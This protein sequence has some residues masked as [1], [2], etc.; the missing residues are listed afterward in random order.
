MECLLWYQWIKNSIKLIF[1]SN[2]TVAVMGLSVIF[3]YF[4]QRKNTRKDAAKIIVQEIRRAED[5]IMRYKEQGNFQFTKKII[6][7]NSWGDNIHFFVNDL[8]QDEL[9]K[10]SNLYSTG[11]FFDY[12]IQRIFNYQF[13]ENAN[14]S[15]EATLTSPIKDFWTVLLTSLVINYDFVYHTEIV[16]KLKRIA[17]IK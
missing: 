11:E 4:W 9:D 15:K 2:F 3:V 12:C 14:R 8:N 13:D 16:T 5:I 17:R 10:I 1:N 7:N 6:A